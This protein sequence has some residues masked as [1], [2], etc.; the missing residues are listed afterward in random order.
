MQRVE[1]KTSLGFTPLKASFLFL[2][3]KESLLWKLYLSI[4]AAWYLTT[5]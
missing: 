5:G 3:K 1:A 4:L 2:R